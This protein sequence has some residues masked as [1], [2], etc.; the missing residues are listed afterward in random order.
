MNS[1][2]AGK[3]SKMV[4]A[5]RKVLKAAMSPD[6]DDSERSA[7]LNS[8][9]ED[10]LAFFRDNDGDREQG[11]AH[12]IGSMIFGHSN[13]VAIMLDQEKQYVQVGLLTATCILSSYFS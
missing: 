3:K 11:Q 8:L 6:K 9:T 2:G 1:L 10:C 5:A 13:F 4:S 12:L 7:A